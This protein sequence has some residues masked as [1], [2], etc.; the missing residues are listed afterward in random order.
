MCETEM[1]AVALVFFMM[2]ILGISLFSFFHR[3]IAD[4]MG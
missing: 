3:R 1:V 4:N 2:F